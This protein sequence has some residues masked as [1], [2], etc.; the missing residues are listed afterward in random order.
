MPGGRTTEELGIAH[1]KELCRAVRRAQRIGP[2][3]S[4]GRLINQCHELLPLVGLACCLAQIVIHYG[5]ARSL[6][7]PAHEAV[8]QLRIA[9]ATALHN[10]SSQLSEDIAQSKHFFFL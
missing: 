3:T 4:L 6:R 9:S 1:S 10:A 7:E 2:D 8:F 5:A